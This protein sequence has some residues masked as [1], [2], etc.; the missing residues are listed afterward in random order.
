ML[1]KAL[2]L[3]ALACLMA[4]PR[5]GGADGPSRVNRERIEELIAASKAETVAVAFYDLQTREEFYIKPEESFHAASTMKI[6]V[7]MEVFRQAAAGSLKLD[8]PVVVKNDFRS[9]ADASLYSISPDSDSEQS[10]YK[11][12]G[13]TEKVGELVKLMITV[14]SN[15]ATNILIE[16]VGPSRV[17]D[18]I[19]KLGAQKMRVLRGVEDSKAYELGMNNTATAHDLTVLLRAI[20]EGRAVS[21]KASDEMTR[22]MLDQKFNEAIPAGLPAGAR[23]AH[24]TGSIT[25]INHD[26]AI[27][28][29]PNRKP[30]VLV[31][32]TRGIEDENRAH[33][34]IADI[35][36]TIY[37]AVA[38]GK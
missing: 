19:R 25:K 6:A 5:A 14:S 11:K 22:V 27:V 3:A 13:Q 9:I 38:G 18:L 23:V 29:P 20:A 26:A 34:L 36:K 4:Q 10:L 8:D 21:R 12:I 15:L 35:S 2:F 17:M 16:Q 7:M 28:F 1:K 32:L 30:Y 24:K 37:N 33:K 31:V